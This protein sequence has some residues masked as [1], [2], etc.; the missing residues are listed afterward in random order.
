M[1]PNEIGECVRV[2]VFGDLAGERDVV[3]TKVAPLECTGF[4]A[5]QASVNAD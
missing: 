4:T 5:A 3:V 1:V 2:T